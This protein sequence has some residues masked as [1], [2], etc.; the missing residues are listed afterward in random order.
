MKTKTPPPYQIK[1][2]KRAKVNNVKIYLKAFR[3]NPAYPYLEPNQTPRVF[4]YIVSGSDGGS[5]K[6]ADYEKAVARFEAY[7]EFEKRQLTIT[8]Q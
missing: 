7:I 2:L 4:Y 6:L 3:E 1:I 5:C 8:K